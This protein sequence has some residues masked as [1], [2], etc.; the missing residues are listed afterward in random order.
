L[1]Y[2]FE[3]FGVG[4]KAKAAIKKLLRSWKKSK[5]RYEKDK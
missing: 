5:N 2:G 1:I 3:I 4:K